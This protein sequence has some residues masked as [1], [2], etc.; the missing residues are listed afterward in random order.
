MPMSKLPFALLLPGFQ[1]IESASLVKSRRK[2][3]PSP[4]D[5]EKTRGPT[6]IC[7]R[8]ALHSKDIQHQTISH[9]RVILGS[10]SLSSASCEPPEWWKINP[11]FRAYREKLRTING[12]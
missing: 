2:L 8:K 6:A 9:Y 12:F 10:L 5:A 4:D 7:L 1:Q 11:L 3:G